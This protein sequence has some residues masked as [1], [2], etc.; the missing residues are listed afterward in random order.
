MGDLVLEEVAMSLFDHGG[1]TGAG[2]AG[3]EGMFCRVINVQIKD[4][5][6]F[7]GLCLSVFVNQSVSRFWG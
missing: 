3:A 6:Y 1:C 5:M 2:G 4:E 7:R